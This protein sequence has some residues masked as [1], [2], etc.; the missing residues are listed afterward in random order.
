[1][2]PCRRPQPGEPMVGQLG[3][4]EAEEE[5][6]VEPLATPPIILSPLC[7]GCGKDLTLGAHSIVYEVDN[8]TLCP[9]CYEGDAR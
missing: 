4:F 7:M 1:M 6:D 5:V 9:T 2:L 3:L 8:R